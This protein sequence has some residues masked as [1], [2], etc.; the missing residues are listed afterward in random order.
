LV[1]WD[2]NDPA[3][4]PLQLEQHVDE[5]VIWSATR[6]RAASGGGSVALATPVMGDVAEWDALHVRLVAPQPLAPSGPCDVGC[7]GGAVDVIGQLYIEPGTNMQRPTPH[8][9]ASEGTLVLIGQPG[10]VA[11]HA[12]VRLDDRAYPVVVN[13]PSADI[14]QVPWMA[15][16]RAWV[17]FLPAQDAP[18]PRRL[19]QMRCSSQ[20]HTL[21][22][23]GSVALGEEVLGFY[24]TGEVAVAAT[25]TRLVFIGPSCAAVGAP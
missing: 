11:L 21:E 6:V 9:L 17:D 20:E 1:A 14:P 12:A 4:F 18:A 8:R 2:L 23:L 3:A 22:A 25:P 10:E 5:F 15:D 19:Q 7:P 16:G 24:D 13:L